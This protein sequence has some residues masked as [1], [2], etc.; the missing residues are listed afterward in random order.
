[1]S[2]VTGAIGEI[3]KELNGLKKSF[4]DIGLK[5]FTNEIKD[6]FSG[7]QTSIDEIQKSAQ[8]LSATFDFSDNGAG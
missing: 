6:S 5:E 4:N 1:L 7:L 8:T 2:N 3:V